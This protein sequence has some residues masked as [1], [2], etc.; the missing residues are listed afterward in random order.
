MGLAIVAV[1]CRLC[2]DG[3]LAETAEAGAENPVN[4]K[5]VFHERL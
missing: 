3:V 5:T 1:R 4:E 2:G